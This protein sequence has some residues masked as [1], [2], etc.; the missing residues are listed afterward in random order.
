MKRI[1]GIVLI[2][3]VLS[4]GISLAKAADDMSELCETIVYAAQLEFSMDENTAA[5][6]ILYNFILNP[7][8]EPLFESYYRTEEKYD[9]DWSDEYVSSLLDKNRPY[10]TVYDTAV[11]DVI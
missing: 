1:I 6:D 9:Y 5:E 10:V 3:S 8:N 7:Y 2:F 11:T 4:F